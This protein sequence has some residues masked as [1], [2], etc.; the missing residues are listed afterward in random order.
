MNDMINSAEHFRKE[1]S[2]MSATLPYSCTPI[3]DEHTLPAK[4]R[5][6]HCIKPGVWAIIRVFDGRLL[7]RVLNP[8]SEAILDCQHPGLVLPNQPHFVEAL[9]PM[10]M[11]IDFYDH[12][13]EL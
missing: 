12:L 11:Q 13:P 5:R 8:V 10:R 4:L 6:A 1:Q 7:Y 9:R 2:S 3:F